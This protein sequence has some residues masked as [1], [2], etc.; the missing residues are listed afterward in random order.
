M[1]KIA[2]RLLLLACSMPGFAA[3][4]DPQGLRDPGG[5]FYFRSQTLQS[6]YAHVAQ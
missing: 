5:R 1:R 2:A 6:Y 3:P 4:S